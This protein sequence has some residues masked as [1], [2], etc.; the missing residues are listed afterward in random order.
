MTA[1]GRAFLDHDIGRFVV[2]I[3]TVNRKYLDIKVSLPG[4]LLRFDLDIRKWVKKMIFRG[5]VLINITACFES[6]SPVRVE[7]NLKYAKELKGAW[8]KI[9][10]ELNVSTENFD[11]N[12]LV[13]DGN[14]FSHIDEI[15][16]EEGV[17]QALYTCV[18]NAL[19]E[20]LEVKNKEG[21][22][23]LEDITMRLSL[24]KDR[25]EDVKSNSKDIVEKNRG[26]LKAQLEEVL[27]G[28][29]ENEER[30]LREVAIFADRVDICEEIVRFN[31]HLQRFHD[32]LQ[33]KHFAIGKKLD[34]LVQE[35]G[36]EANTIASKS[37]DAK[38]SQFVVE[39]K[40]EL[41]KI[42]EQ[43]QNIE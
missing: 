14:L 20:C 4:E 39:I 32:M 23:L 18:N 41:E 21:K 3:Q 27:P 35:M 24:L 19:E 42:R 33:E 13:R 29:V 36:R 8:N 38:V 34:F 17:R 16:D 28:C 10:E 9:A 7:P 11:L 31:A 2:E 5:H 26:R 22:L 1:Y 30:V 15:S 6:F 40:S 12:L 25:I 43:V 37:L